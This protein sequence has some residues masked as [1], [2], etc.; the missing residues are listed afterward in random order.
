[1]MNTVT[2]VGRLTKDVDLK[3][4][5]SG[6]FVANVTVAVNR[7]IKTEGQPEADF[8]PVVV[9]NK[10]ANNLATYTRKGSL[11]GIE[12]RLQTRTY[13]NN[14]Q[15]HYVTEVIAGRVQFLETK[16]SAGQSA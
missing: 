14:G 8:V 1:M 6:T 13:E 11:I 16:K 9:W 4:T 7:A 5:T 12:G 15:T 2:L 3:Q 10:Q